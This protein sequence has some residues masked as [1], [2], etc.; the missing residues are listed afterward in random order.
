MQKKVS[1]TGRYLIPLLA[2]A[3]L[4]GCS[5][6]PMPK[7]NSKGYSSVRFINEK[8]SALFY[9]SDRSKE[10]NQQLQQAIAAQFE[11]KGMDVVEK[12]GDLIVAYLVI[13]QD[14]VSTTSINKHFGYR[15]SD[16]MVD[17][18]HKRG[19]RGRYPEYVKRGAIVID[20]LDAKT[21]KLVYRDYAVRGVNSSLPEE[22]RRTKI[23]EAVE[24]T[25]A[26]F[27]K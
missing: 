27:F 14:N 20:L 26:S 3:L 10:V 25:L 1:F 21:Y 9:E 23:N 4:A 17:K 5:S 7:G 11:E 16:K 2:G 6:V 8:K 22:E 19:T 13:I 15:D 18:V 24:E 12:G